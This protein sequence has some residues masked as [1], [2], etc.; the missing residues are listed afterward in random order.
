[1]SN[2]RIDAGRVEVRSLQVIEVGDETGILLRLSDFEALAL[3]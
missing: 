3:G 2:L 1:M